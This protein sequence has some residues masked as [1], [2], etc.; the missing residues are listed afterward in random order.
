MQWSDDLKYKR[1]KCRRN[2]KC[3]LCTDLR[4]LGNNQGR[5]SMNDSKR[6]GLSSFKRVENYR[7]KPSPLDFYT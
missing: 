6:M 5:R 2:V 4:W 3:C 7:R 1:K